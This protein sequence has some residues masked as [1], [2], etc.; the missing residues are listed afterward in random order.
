MPM[1][2]LNTRNYYLYAAGM[3]L[4][5]LLNITQLSDAAATG[6]PLLVIVEV[7]SSVRQRP[8]AHQLAPLLKSGEIPAGS[9]Y[10]WHNHLAVYGFILQPERLKTALEKLYPH[11]IVKIFQHPYYDFDRTR[12]CGGADI[13]RNW[14]NILLSAD[15]VADPKMQRQY[16]EM[17][18]GQFKHWPDVAKGF[19]NAD[20]QQLLGFKNGRRLILVISIPKGKTLDELNPKTTENNPQMVQWNAMMKKYQVGLPGTKPGEVWVFFKQLTDIQ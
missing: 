14:D 18:A 8:D 15:L 19:C 4:F 2:T 10:Q 20:F 5:M 11:C 9:V 13:A 16:L 12:C 1:K 7:T 17:H 6:K 3:I